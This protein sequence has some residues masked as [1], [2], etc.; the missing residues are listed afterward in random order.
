MANCF[1][2]LVGFALIVIGSGLV[3]VFG[4]FSSFLPEKVTLTNPTV[5]TPRLVVFAPAVAKKVE[6]DQY[7]Y[8][9]YKIW[10]A[11]ISNTNTTDVDVALGDEE[12]TPELY[13]LYNLTNP[14]DFINGQE[15]PNLEEVGPFGYSRILIK[16]NIQLLDDGKVSFTQYSLRKPLSASYCRTIQTEIGHSDPSDCLDPSVQVISLNKPYTAVLNQVNPNTI[17]AIYGSFTA[18]K[19][20]T[21]TVDVVTQY[22]ADPGVGFVLTEYQSD[23]RKST[24]VNE[25]KTAFDAAVT[26]DGDRD[27]VITTLNSAA[28]DTSSP[29]YGISRHFTDIGKAATSAFDTDATLS[30]FFDPT[31]DSSPFSA[32]GYSR[33]RKSNETT[34]KNLLMSFCSADGTTDC[35]D[36]VPAIHDWLFETWAD[37]TETATR[38]YNDF[39]SVNNTVACEDT[40]VWNLF[41]FME[42]HTAAI[43]RDVYDTLFVNETNDLTFLRSENIKRWRDVAEFCKNKDLTCTEFTSVYQTAYWTVFDAMIALDHPSKDR[44]A[45]VATDQLPEQYQSQICSLATYIKTL[46]RNSKVDAGICALIPQLIPQVIQVYPELAEV[47]LVQNLGM[48]QLATAGISKVLWNSDTVNN[49]TEFFH[50]LDTPL[51]IDEAKFLFLIML[52]S[53]FMERVLD[54][55]MTVTNFDNIQAPKQYKLNL[56]GNFYSLGI[57][58]TQAQILMRKNAAQNRTIASDLAQWQVELA[59]KYLIEQHYFCDVLDD[60]DYTRGGLL[61]RAT[62]KELLFDGYSDPGLLLLSQLF[63]NHAGSFDI[64]CY[65]QKYFF[66]DGTSGTEESIGKEFAYSNRCVKTRD[67]HCTRDGIQVVDKDTGLSYNWTRELD[68]LAYYNLSRPSFRIGNITISNLL[69]VSAVQFGATYPDLEFQ[70]KR[71]CVDEKCLRTI[72]SDLTIDCNATLCETPDTTSRG[73]TGML[74]SRGGKTKNSNWKQ[75]SYSGGVTDSPEFLSGQPGEDCPAT[76]KVYSPHI[77]GYI[78]YSRVHQER[79]E[80]DNEITGECR[81]EPTAASFTSTITSLT[82]Q[83]SL[84]PPKGFYPHVPVNGKGNYR[85]EAAP[86]FFLETQVGESTELDKFTGLSPTREKHQSFA[87]YDLASRSLKRKVQRRA[88]YARVLKSSMYPNLL[89]DYYIYPLHSRTSV[90]SQTAVNQ[91]LLLIQ[92]VPFTVAEEALEFIHFIRGYSVNPS[93]FILIGSILG[94]V[95]AVSGLLLVC[96][97][98][99]KKPKS[100]DAIQ[101][102]S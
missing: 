58:P 3:L 87:E 38:M 29:Y 96:I 79:N 24:G 89:Q 90:Y 20:L 80:L 14:K 62:A 6:I 21:D 7:N 32:T 82:S 22:V 65:N 56:K 54:L 13:Y 15:K 10:N 33:W 99:K 78:F 25:L 18:R 1:K 95:L 8:E 42:N 75:S 98:Q 53:G 85:C 76:R 44:A 60:C 94:A 52:N 55:A 61:V 36:R 51:T 34:E 73:D 83:S 41:P 23:F 70:R 97:Q 67:L 91:T 64:Q 93:E 11:F 26:A 100:S 66:T 92:P 59:Q 40:C 5:D 30:S 102:K 49:H 37:R 63:T 12:G 9:H 28:D 84:L 74:V 81:Y 46:Y 69:P 57:H 50:H 45:A 101:P 68:E 48:F 27:N 2:K 39:V 71:S 43:T 72:Q 19:F 35:E 77:D 16:D 31:H 17:T 47:E 86:S 4:V 88:E